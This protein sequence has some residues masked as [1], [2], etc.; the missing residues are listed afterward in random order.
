MIDRS[1]RLPVGVDG[2]ITGEKLRE[3]LL[4][5]LRTHPVY[6]VLHFVLHPVEPVTVREGYYETEGGAVYPPVE[7]VSGERHQTFLQQIVG[8]WTE[9]I[10]SGSA[11]PCHPRAFS[12]STSRFPS[13][14]S[15]CCF[16][17][18]GFRR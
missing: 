1:N 16:S 18:L 12:P 6:V 14:A 2:P 9:E 11:V 5:Q 3:H 10:V 13:S 17:V 7:V 8:E 4:I 15:L